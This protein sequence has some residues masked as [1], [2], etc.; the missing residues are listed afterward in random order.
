[1]HST[2]HES[3]YN[4]CDTTR[5]RLSLRPHTLWF[6]ALAL[7]VA[8]SVS[9]AQ[10]PFTE[11]ADTGDLGSDFRYNFGGSW[12]DFDEDGDM[13]LLTAN[14]LQTGNSLLRNNGDLTFTRM[15]A[16]Q[17]GDLGIG[18]TPT[19]ESARISPIFSLPFL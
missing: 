13:D 2:S 12:G 19:W 9:P 14:G 7:L 5:S 16:A 18:R 10:V 15:T 17:I 6:I 1:M 8:T 3:R 11:V 4:A